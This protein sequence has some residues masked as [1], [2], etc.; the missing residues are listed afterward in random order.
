MEDFSIE[1]GAIWK[2]VYYSSE[3]IYL[4]D[5]DRQNHLDDLTKNITS[6]F[7][8]PAG[9]SPEDYSTLFLQQVIKTRSDGNTQLD[10]I[11]H[12]TRFVDQFQIGNKECLDH[13]KKIEASSF[14]DSWE[15]ESLVRY[16]IDCSKFYM[17]E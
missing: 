10:N 8:P 16:F 11:K 15:N 17:H 13:I 6:T 1:Y 14:F 9:L 2:L 5:L 4:S 3:K 7:N 12:K